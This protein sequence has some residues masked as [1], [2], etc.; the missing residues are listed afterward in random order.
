MHPHLSNHREELEKIM[1]P[2]IVAI[3]LHP[4]K[5]NPLDITRLEIA[6]QKLV[7]AIYGEKVMF[8]L[9]EGNVG[10]DSDENMLDIKAELSPANKH[11]LEKALEEIFGS[12]IAV[13]Y[14]GKPVRLSVAMKIAAAAKEVTKSFNSQ[15]E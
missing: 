3:T 9:T 13:G 8:D 7:V 1:P 6:L 15:K 12:S 4:S 5:T 11:A 2:R 14:R 10:D